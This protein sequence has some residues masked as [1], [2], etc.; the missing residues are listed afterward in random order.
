MKAA[1]KIIL[2]VLLAA[3]IG[4]VGYMATKFSD[5]PVSEIL[6]GR[7]TSSE[8][9]SSVTE[10]SQTLL[11]SFRNVDRLR[12]DTDVFNDPAYKSLQEIVI[13]V[14]NNVVEGRPDPFK[15]IGNESVTRDGSLTI[16]EVDADEIEESQ[17]EE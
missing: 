4:V 1:L 17:D 9:V 8:G 3:L 12:L 11:N 10:N 2:I 15:T 13:S 16:F 7:S 14:P 6:T 5:V